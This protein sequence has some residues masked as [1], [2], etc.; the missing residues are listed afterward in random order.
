MIFGLW[1]KHRLLLESVPGLLSPGGGLPPI[2]IVV[3]R[4][5]AGIR[6]IIMKYILKLKIT[7][8]IF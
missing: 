7:R 4:V 2:I 8:G 3:T 1:G 5:K 6:N